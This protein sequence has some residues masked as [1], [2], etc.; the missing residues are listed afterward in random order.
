[1]EE[2]I[3][4]AHLFSFSFPLPHRAV[5][6]EGKEVLIYLIEVSQVLRQ[7]QNRFSENRGFL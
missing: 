5:V 6:K 2:G 7:D 4:F 1:M 3:S